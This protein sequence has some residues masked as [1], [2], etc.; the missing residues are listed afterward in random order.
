MVKTIFNGRFPKDK[1]YADFTENIIQTQE[2]VETNGWYLTCT[3]KCTKLHSSNMCFNAFGIFT[4]KHTFWLFEL[5]NKLSFG[6]GTGKIEETAVSKSN[7]RWDESWCFLLTGRHR[8]SS[9][10][11]LWTQSSDSKH[12]ANT[13][14]NQVWFFFFFTKDESFYSLKVL[15]DK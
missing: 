7:P 12:K 15:P 5:K 4:Q 13:V 9:E 1:N 11:S 8:E 3:N 2:Q 14:I 6:Q 10:R